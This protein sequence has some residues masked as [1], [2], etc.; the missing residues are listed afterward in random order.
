MTSIRKI[1]IYGLLLCAR[2]VLFGQ[3]VHGAIG[4]DALGVFGIKIDSLKKA[5]IDTFFVYYPY[6]YSDGYYIPDNSTK[7]QVREIECENTKQ[8]FIFYRQ[9]GITFVTKINECY[10]F[11]PIRLDT[12]KAFS[13]FFTNFQK[14]L[15][16][17]FIRESA[18]I[19]K[20]GEKQGLGSEHSCYNTLYLSLTQSK[21][22]WLDRNH[23]KEKIQ[24]N[25]NLKK[26]RTN[27]FY[28]HN[29]KTPV[30]IFIDLV[31]KELDR[32]KFVQ[33]ALEK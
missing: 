28:E 20:K 21:Y 3:D 23:F 11:S 2:T 24:D 32:I 5:G 1:F 7:E 18:Y 4:V 33:Q 19:D 17:D 31:T 16:E 14:L 30:K 10:R 8:T 26:M 25:H 22:Y 9:K 29:A 15:I 13:F 27:M 12:S 6:C